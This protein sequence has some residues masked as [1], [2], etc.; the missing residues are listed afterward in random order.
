MT[1]SDWK[2]VTILTLLVL[3]DEQEGNKKFYLSKNLGNILCRLT[4]P[5]YYAFT[6]KKYKSMVQIKLELSRTCSINQPID[7]P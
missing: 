3:D 4:L 2:F 5:D 7:R 1:P 6:F